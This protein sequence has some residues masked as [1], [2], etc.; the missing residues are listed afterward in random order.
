MPINLDTVTEGLVLGTGT[1]S[2]TPVGTPRGVLGISIRAVGAADT[3][4]MDY[5][6]VTMTQLANSPFVRA[7]GEPFAIEVYFL[8]AGIPTGTQDLS[9]TAATEANKKIYCVTFTADDDTEF[10]ADDQIEG[11]AV[12]PSGTLALGG[13]V[14]AVVQ[15]FFAGGNNIANYTPLA[16]WTEQDEQATPGFSFGLYSFD[17]VGSADVTYGY[18]GAS[19]DYGI[20]AIAIREVA[21]AGPDST[22]SGTPQAQDASVTGTGA[23]G[24]TSSGALASQDAVASGSGQRGASGSGAL[25]SQDVTVVGSGSIQGA[26]SGSGAVQSDDASVDGAGTVTSVITGSG[27]L[28]AQS[29]TVVGSGQR[30]AQDTGTTED[31]SAGDATVVG[32]AKTRH[33]GSG[34][35]SAQS[36]SVVGSGVVSGDI[37]GSGSLDSQSASVSG[38]GDVGRQGSGVLQSEDSQT[39][40]SGSVAQ[41]ITGSGAL[42]SE[43]AS[44]Q[45]SGTSTELQTIFTAPATEG[46]GFVQDAAISDSVVA[47]PVE[48]TGQIP[49]AQLQVLTSPV[50]VAVEGQ[51][52]ITGGELLVG[53]IFAV[54]PTEGSGE[55][56]D[57]E[58]IRFGAKS[59]EGR[60]EILSKEIV[61]TLFSRKYYLT[62]RGL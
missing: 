49:D 33:V 23:R 11:D 20:Y 19:D 30:G 26:V 28:Q 22:G 32:V 51:G 57:V 62:I 24:A 59:V 54:Q 58:I 12:D 53:T 55:A 56:L 25:A 17:T 40:G 61:P 52:E 60:G 6:G 5:G 7:T 36:A 35:L 50:G 47:L 29:A 8:G 27:A 44:M 1:L 2:H 14:S 45:G 16:G 42:Q 41:Q 9:I 38:S 31:L 4:D 3:S 10:V 15:A 37:S 46:R 21:G 13:I 18:T 39:V 34:G 48:G 43:A